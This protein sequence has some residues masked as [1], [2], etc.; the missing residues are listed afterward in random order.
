MIE[1][2]GRLNTLANWE[3]WTLRDAPDYQLPPGVIANQ[4]VVELR[5]ET[6]QDAWL[7]M[8]SRT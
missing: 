4:L 3:G 5:E 8:P 7:T 1:L 6:D 2:E